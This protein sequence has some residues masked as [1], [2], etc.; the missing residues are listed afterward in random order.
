MHACSALV[1]ECMFCVFLTAPK[2]VPFNWKEY[3]HRAALWQV[4]EGG[5]VF[6]SETWASK[7]A[8]EHG[9]DGYP[10]NPNTELPVDGAQGKC[11]WCPAVW[12][13]WLKNSNPGRE[14]ELKCNF[15]GAL[16]LL[17]RPSTLKPKL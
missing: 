9:E 4:K 5:E 13:L 2:S 10:V 14:P 17:L 15:W 3:A 1:T 11:C 7:C 16:Q 8:D 12:H 6:C